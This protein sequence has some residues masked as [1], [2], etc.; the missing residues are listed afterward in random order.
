MITSIGQAV[1][2]LIGWTSLSP[3]FG[4]FLAEAAEKT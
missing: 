4:H 2:L 1:V 3:N